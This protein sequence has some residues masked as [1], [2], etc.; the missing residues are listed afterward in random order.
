MIFYHGT[1][2]IK[3]IIIKLVMSIIGIIYEK[4]NFDKTS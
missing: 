3:I 2:I 1:K 4:S